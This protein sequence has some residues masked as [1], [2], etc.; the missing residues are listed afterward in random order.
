ME[1]TGSWGITRTG[2]VN[3]SGKARSN[4]DLVEFEKTVIES[5]CDKKQNHA[6]RHSSMRAP[7][8]S[9]QNPLAF[10]GR[11]SA[12]VVWLFGMPQNR[13][14]SLRRNCDGHTLKKSCTLK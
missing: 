12:H 2:R 10:R 6:R 9:V 3:K 1:C 14:A 8:R 7:W 5:G 11:H 4:N 13:P